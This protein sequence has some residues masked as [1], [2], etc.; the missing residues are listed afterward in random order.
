MLRVNRH[1]PSLI[2]ALDVD[3]FGDAHTLVEQLCG[4]VRIF[5]VGLQLFTICGPEVIR[6]IREKKC[7]V[8]LDL[9][10]HDIPNTVA[11]ASESAVK[12]NVL[13]FNIHA[14]GGVKMM[15][16]AV[17]SCRNASERL[18]T[19]KP[20]VL[21]VTL[22]TSIG[23]DE[24]EKLNV[25]YSAGEYVAHLTHMALEAGVDG[26]VASGEEIDRIRQIAGENFK[27]VIPGV[28]PSW[29]PSNDQK[30]TVTPKEAFERGADFIVV[31]RPIIK[32]ADPLAATRRI[33]DE[34]GK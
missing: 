3:S 31:G 10:F 20:M 33:L 5:K 2:V 12:H 26:V 32:A 15:Q 9:K 23:S 4:M 7:D 30:R 25:A 1:F 16:E 28:R 13:M 14:L 17:L 34:I 24:L 8:F 11:K 19:R 22:L 21:A 27:I 6:M 18:H 29:A